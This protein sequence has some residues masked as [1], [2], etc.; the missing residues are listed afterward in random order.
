[1]DF[2]DPYLKAE[3]YLVVDAK[4]ENVAGCADLEGKSV[5]ALSG[6]MGLAAIE[7]NRDKFNLTVV[8]YDDFGDYVVDLHLGELGAFVSELILV[9]NLNRSA[10]FRDSF[11]TVGTPVATEYFG[12]AVRKCDSKTLALINGGLRK[13][14]ASGKSKVLEQRWLK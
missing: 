14:I 10:E 1:M 3:Y 8:P 9:S 7:N 13:F 5:G 11:K 4:T 2:S 12:I 6:S